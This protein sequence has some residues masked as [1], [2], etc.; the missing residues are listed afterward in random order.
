MTNEM[1]PT[2]SQDANL[3]SRVE[4]CTHSRIVDDVLSSRGTKTGQL[5]CLECQAVFPDPASHSSNH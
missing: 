4:S 3:T 5:I 1:P 2:M